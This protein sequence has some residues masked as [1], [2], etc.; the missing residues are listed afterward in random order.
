MGGCYGMC[1]RCCGIKKVVIGALLLLNAFYW[2]LW[3]GIDGWA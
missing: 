1:P 3:T 2:P